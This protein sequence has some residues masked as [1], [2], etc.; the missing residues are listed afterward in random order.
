MV[1]SINSV[2]TGD[3]HHM[4]SIVTAT[5]PIFGPDVCAISVCMEYC[6]S[7]PGGGVPSSDDI[8]LSGLVSPPPDIVSSFLVIVDA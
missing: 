3:G 4:A 5:V 8:G 2:V 1:V 7:D 6:S